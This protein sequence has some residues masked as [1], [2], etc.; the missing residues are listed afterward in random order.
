MK[1]PTGTVNC[2][3]KIRSYGIGNILRNTNFQAY[4]LN[5]INLFILAQ[6]DQP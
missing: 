1:K 6:A 5:E 2:M 4:I 3:A